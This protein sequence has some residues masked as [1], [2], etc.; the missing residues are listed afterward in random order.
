M[1][2][3]HDN[4][5]TDKE[6]LESEITDGEIVDAYASIQLFPE[7]IAQTLADLE[8]KIDYVVGVANKLDKF[9]E[10]MAPMLEMFGNMNNNGAAP[11]PLNLM[12]LAMG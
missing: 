7:E 4:A 12:H 5:I 10:A 8:A 2:D 1:N 3:E 6:M 9:L 11:N